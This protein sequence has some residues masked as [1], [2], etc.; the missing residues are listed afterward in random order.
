MSAAAF[1]AILNESDLQLTPDQGG[2]SV[3]VADT[4][5]AAGSDVDGFD[6]EVL[7]LADD[8]AALAGAWDAFGPD[9]DQQE[10]VFAELDPQSLAAD[11]LA[12]PGV[13]AEGDA[14]AADYGA[15]GFGQPPPPANPPPPYVLSGS[16][17]GD[18]VPP[19][20][21]MPSADPCAETTA[22]ETVFDAVTGTYITCGLP[23]IT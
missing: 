18:V 15:L 19:P 11:A 13:L 5:G 20:Q 4:L 21:P 10:A 16:G 7:A 1:P 22:G 17:G 14:I 12:F 6:P 2:F 8:E 23:L 9:A 3:M